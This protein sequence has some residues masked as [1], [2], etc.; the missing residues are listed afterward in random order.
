MAR[1][2]SSFVDGIQMRLQRA[3]RPY[4]SHHREPVRASDNKKPQRKEA[5]RESLRL[6]NSYYDTP[7]RYPTKSMLFWVDLVEYRL[8]NAVF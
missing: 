8:K 6:W 3:E 2:S 1:R 7:T 5:F 4:L